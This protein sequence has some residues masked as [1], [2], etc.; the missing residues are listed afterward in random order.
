MNRFSSLIPLTL[1]GGCGILTGEYGNSDASFS[2]TK[3]RQA[4]ATFQPEFEKQAQRRE[5]KRQQKQ[6]HVT[7]NHDNP[8]TIQQR[9][10][11][12]SSLAQGKPTEVQDEKPN[13]GSSP[14]R[15]S[16]ILGWFSFTR[17]TNSVRDPPITRDGGKG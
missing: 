4:V 12:P 9:S 11:Q 13:P 1:V 16:R 15:T 7:D 5:E 10:Q 6:L 17:A 3:F 2:L 14:P 8:V